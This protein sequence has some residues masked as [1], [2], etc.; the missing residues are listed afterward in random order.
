MSLPKQDSFARIQNRKNDACH[1][2]LTKNLHKHVVK[3]QSIFLETLS[4]M[5]C[6]GNR[7]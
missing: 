1:I 4:E 2:F 6:L 3:R 5:L 7:V